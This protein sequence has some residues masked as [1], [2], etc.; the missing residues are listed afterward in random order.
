MSPHQHSGLCS[1]APTTPGSRL[2]SGDMALKRWVTPRTPAARPRAISSKVALVWPAETT[3]P[4]F[5]S[6]AI[7]SGV[8]I[9]G[10]SV[11]SVRPTPSEVSSAHAG[12]VQIAELGRVVHALARSR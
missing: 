7:D 1:A 12:V 9:S 6:R 2:V 5:A 8:V 10:A 3:T 4:A 11:T